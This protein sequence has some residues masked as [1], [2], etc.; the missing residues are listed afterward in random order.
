MRFIAKPHFSDTVG[1]SDKDVESVGQSLVRKAVI[2]ADSKFIALPSL[3][4][5]LENEGTV[6]RK[7]LQSKRAS[8]TVSNFFDREL[9]DFLV[10]EGMSSDPGDYARACSEGSHEKAS[11]HESTRQA[12][13]SFKTMSHRVFLLPR[14]R[15]SRNYQARSRTSAWPTNSKRSMGCWPLSP[16]R[17]ALRH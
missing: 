2:D 1:N 4:M 7:P 11:R 14:G 8:L 9:P 13:G 17:W 16:L 3:L 6:D 5:A 15:G 12:S 10:L